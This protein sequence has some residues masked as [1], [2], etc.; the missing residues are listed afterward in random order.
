MIATGIIAA[1]LILHIVFV[2]LDAT[3]ATTS[4]ARTRPGPHAGHLFLNCSLRPTQA[5]SRANYGV[6]TMF[7]LVVGESSHRSSA[8]LAHRDC[9]IDDSC[10]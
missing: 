2:L 9:T 3:A 4:S 5:G 6:A 7:Y 8:H 10:G 1:I